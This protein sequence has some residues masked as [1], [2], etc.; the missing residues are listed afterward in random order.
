MPVFACTHSP[1]M[2]ASLRSNVGQLSC[3]SG[4]RT[5]RKLFAPLLYDTL[6]HVLKRVC[7]NKLRVLVSSSNHDGSDLVAYGVSHRGAI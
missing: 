2:Y 7:G 4:P 5:Y 3:V 1:L 6:G